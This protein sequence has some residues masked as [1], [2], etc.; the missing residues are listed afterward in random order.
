MSA[1]SQ[2]IHKQKGLTLLE[3]MVVASIIAIL[4]G[5]AVPS[6]MRAREHGRA[7]ACQE[8]LTQIDGAKEIYALEHNLPNG[9]IVSMSDLMGGG[10]GY[11]KREPVCPAGGVYSIEPIGTEPSCSYYGREQYDV[12]PHKLPVNR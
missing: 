2:H 7:R 4:I 11:L 8:N 12:P 9:A 10:S 6:W 1:L 3:I 5:I